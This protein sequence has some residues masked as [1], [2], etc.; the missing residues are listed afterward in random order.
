MQVE[1]CSKERKGTGVQGLNPL[2]PKKENLVLV[3]EKQPLCDKF[4][5]S[6]YLFARQCMDIIG[7]CY[8]S[9]TSGSSRVKYF[10]C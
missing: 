9:I 6:H 7:R 3:Q 5:Y 8:L 2:T 10:G 1:H 4:K